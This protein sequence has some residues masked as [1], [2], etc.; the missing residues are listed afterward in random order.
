M[1][2]CVD[3]RVDVGVLMVD[4]NYKSMHCNTYC[5]PA[6]TL[7][8]FCICLFS[9]CLGLHAGSQ[10]YVIGRVSIDTDV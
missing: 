5:R 3:C 9:I 6:V 2:I 7:I 8:I 1:C 10:A 4:Y